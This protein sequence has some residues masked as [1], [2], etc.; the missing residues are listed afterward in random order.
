VVLAILGG[1]AALAQADISAVY[2]ETRAGE[3]GS[4]GLAAASVLHI[5]G[6]SFVP[7][8]SATVFLADGNGAVAVTGSSA[9]YMHAPVLLPDGAQ[10]SG[11]TFYYYDNLNPDTM[12]ARLIRNND[13]GTGLRT[14]L[15]EAASPAGGAGY[16]SAYGSVG[17]TPIVID[18]ACYNYEIEVSWTVGSSNLK[19][20]SVKVYYTNP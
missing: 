9:R 13:P 15:A 8:S 18:N 1:V 16:G 4:D 12:T 5:A 7:E 3:A 19:L 17:P 10:V 14:V 6:A 20:T 2:G 11:L